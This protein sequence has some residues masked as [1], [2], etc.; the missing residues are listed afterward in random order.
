MAVKTHGPS[1][2]E[3]ERAVAIAE[4]R[5]VDAP[6]DAAYDRC[7]NRFEDLN[8]E[9]DVARRRAELASTDD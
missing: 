8:Y 4:Q 2:A 3:L 1:V 7:K 9:L 5:M 6:S